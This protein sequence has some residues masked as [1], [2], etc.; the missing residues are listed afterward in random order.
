MLTG[1][2]NPT[3]ITSMAEYLIVSH[4]IM[5]HKAWR[6]VFFFFFFSLKRSTHTATHNGVKAAPMPGNVSTTNCYGDEN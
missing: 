5:N 3:L 1:Q 2:L 4:V 6:D